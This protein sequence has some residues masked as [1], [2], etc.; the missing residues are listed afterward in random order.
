[1]PAT[2]DRIT[3]RLRRSDD[4]VLTEMA[5]SLLR[6]GRPADDAS[7]GRPALARREARS[8]CARLSASRLTGASWRS[9]LRAGTAPVA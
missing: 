1:M 7:A 2:T 6:E 3:A 5:R 9:R 8:T 4:A